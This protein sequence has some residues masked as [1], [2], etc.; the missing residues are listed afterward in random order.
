VLDVSET[1]VK[2][3]NFRIRAIAACL[4]MMS[5]AVIAHAGVNGAGGFRDEVVLQDLVQPTDVAFGNNGHVFVAEQRGT[6]QLFESFAD[7]TPTTVVDLRTE[8]HNYWDRGLLGVELH[9]EYPDTPWLYVLYTDDAPPGNT[10][11]W[12]GDPGQD[13]D[14]CPDPPGGIDAGCVAGGVVARVLI[15]PVQLTAGLPETLLSGWCQQFRSHS[16]GDL[17]YGAD[18]ALYVTGGDGAAAHTVDTGQLGHDY[19]G[20]NPC[21]DPADEGGALRAQDLASPADPAGFNGALL[22]I[23]PDT[24]AALPD[25]PLVGAGSSDDDRIVAYGLRNPFR[26][27]IDP[28]S[29]AI[30]L[31]DVGWDAFEEVNEVADPT[32]ALVENFG[33]PCREGAAAQPGYAGTAL[34][35][36]VNAGG[37]PVGTLTDALLAVDHTSPPGPERCT[38][39]GAF[40]TGIAFSGDSYPTSWTDSLYVIDAGS[41]CMWAMPRGGGGAPDPA[42]IATFPVR[43]LGAVALVDGP[44]GEIY[45]P[46]LYLGRVHRLRSDP[47][48]VFADDF[49]Y[50]FYRWDSVVAATT[51]DPDSVSARASN[52]AAGLVGK[53]GPPDRIPR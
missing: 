14:T 27:A 9:P 45:Y 30:Y 12:W 24:G 32:D 49:E 31:A 7:P 51:D 37:D 42:S 40:L 17:V 28:D 6:V 23:D 22:R 19:W 44:G 18:G 10:P 38:A 48:L 16:I 46:N 5:A 39:S 41:G 13:S 50:G 4:V 53:A 35:Q 43:L 25:N 3:M 36:V 1:G 20:G 8:V 34:C 21:G 15:D 29:G 52:A 33:W 26:F 2:T 11:P 47:D